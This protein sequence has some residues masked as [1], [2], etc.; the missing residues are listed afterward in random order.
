MGRALVVVGTGRPDSSSSG[1]ARPS[2]S[3]I[4]AIQPHGPH[5]PSRSGPVQ[6]TLTPWWWSWWTPPASGAD[7]DV[8]VQ[9]GP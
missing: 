5:G 2:A 8:V 6:P 3:R 7:Q 9:P 4:T 1:S